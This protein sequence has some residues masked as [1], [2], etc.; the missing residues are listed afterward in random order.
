MIFN[1]YRQKNGD[2][3]L[4][5]NCEYKS[6]DSYRVVETDEYR[7]QI[8]IGTTLAS[9]YGS[10]TAFSTGLRPSVNTYK[11]ITARASGSDRCYDI[12]RDGASSCTC[13]VW[14]H[15]KYNGVGPDPGY[16]WAY[17][18]YCY[19]DSYPT[20]K[21]VQGSLIGSVILPK[22]TVY[23]EQDKGYTYVTTTSGAIIM[24]YGS[25]YYWYVKQT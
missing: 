2:V 13:Y 5:Y 4:K 16:A 1:L 22:D 7:W 6:V 21:Y 11:T 18:C 14:N 25:N 23:P 8:P 12:P 3:W 24:K 17:S 19:S 15:T 9:G 20:W 10:I